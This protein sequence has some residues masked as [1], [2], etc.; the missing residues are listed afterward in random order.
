MNARQKAKKLKKE[1]EKLKADRTGAFKWLK[2][3]GAGVRM[4][5]NEF[6]YYSDDRIIVQRQIYQFRIGKTVFES[7]LAS[8]DELVI[9]DSEKLDNAYKNAMKMREVEDE[10]YQSM[11]T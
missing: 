8:G 6:N 4:E 5:P 2:I 1:L 7:E 10:I 3:D 9:I 11:D